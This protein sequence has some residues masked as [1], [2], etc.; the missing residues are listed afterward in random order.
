MICLTLWGCLATVSPVGASHLGNSIS[1]AISVP[2]K[3]KWEHYRISVYLIYLPAYLEVYLSGSWLR[4][5]YCQWITAPQNFP[6]L[7]GLQNG[8]DRRWKILR[9][10]L[11]SS[12][13]LSTSWGN[14]QDGAKKEKGNYVSEQNTVLGTLQNLYDL[15]YNSIW[16]VWLLSPIC[17]WENWGSERF[18]LPKVTWVINNKGWFKPGSLWLKSVAFCDTC[19]P[20]SLPGDVLALGVKKKSRRQADIGSSPTSATNQQ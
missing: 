5:Y 2:A 9:Y 8:T 14:D 18:Y 6:V 20:K 3:P 12:K 7:L 19:C 1:L 17:R 10:S 13:P 16:W 4:F 11:E 15:H